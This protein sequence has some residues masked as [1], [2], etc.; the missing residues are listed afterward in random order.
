[1]ALVLLVPGISN[2]QVGEIPRSSVTY[3]K[4][5]LNEY[6]KTVANGIA[7]G[8]VGENRGKILVASGA[9]SAIRLVDPDT[10][11][12]VK[13]YGPEHGVAF[14]D[15][16]AEGPDGTLY[17][18]NVITESVG[19]IGPNGETGVVAHPVPFVNSV[20]VSPDGRQLF[21]TKCIWGD[22]MYRLDLTKPDAQPEE[23]AT[24]IGWPNSMQFGP[25]GYLYGPTNLFGEI[26]RWDPKSASGAR[27]VVY[28]GLEFPSALEMDA[29]GNI[30]TSEF[31]TGYVSKI[32]PKTGERKILA[33]FPPGLDN[34]AVS[35]E[36]RVFVS[37]FPF[38]SIVEVFELDPPKTVTGGGGLLPEGIAVVPGPDGD[39]I[40]LKD[41]FRLA[42][43]QPESGEIRTL[44]TAGF[45]EQI[46][47][48]QPKFDR[49]IT[50]NASGVAK[51]YFYGT[52]HSVGGR[53]L[54]GS[55]AFLAGAPGTLTVYDV[56]REEVVR[57]VTGL[58][59]PLDGTQ[60]G[61]D[62]YVVLGPEKTIIR[63]TPS[64]ERDVVFR[65]SYPL[66]LTQT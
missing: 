33:K 62:L 14:P 19:K 53:K 31:L 3:E 49:A 54:V 43:L 21:F 23:L 25:D 32:D 29:E 38:D 4:T 58:P 13:E 56:E 16:V 66:A 26:L 10:G 52:L 46:E 2:A 40:F 42:E 1:L 44:D 28:E 59:G 57:E 48:Q 15:D 41:R 27:K 63:I 24:N 12:T 45:R 30:Y 51:L 35:P 61:D 20:A 5:V 50:L 55:G 47:A 22:A 34:I 64:G 60:V 8:R 36:G 37:L 9:N 7:W 17:F 18:T 65:S 11:E 39:R 6:M